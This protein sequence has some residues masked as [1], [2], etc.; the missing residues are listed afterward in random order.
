MLGGMVRYPTLKVFL[1]AL[2]NERDC[3]WHLRTVRW[4][5]GDDCPRCGSPDVNLVF[6]GLSGRVRMRLLHHCLECDYHFSATAGT[7]FHDTHL[8]LR[9]WLLAIYLMGSVKNGVQATQLK[10][11]LG[12]N[13]ETARNMVRRI[14]G[15]IKQDKKFVQ[16]CLQ[17][18]EPYGAI[19][20]AAPNRNLHPTLHAIVEKFE[21]EEGCRD[22]LARI[23]WPYGPQC[24]R[25]KKLKVRQIQSKG[26][27][28]RH[29]YR[30]LVCKY[31]FSVITGTPFTRTHL[32]SEWLIAIYLMGSSPRGCPA[33]QLQR[34]LGVNYRTAREMV[35]LLRKS[36]SKSKEVFET[37]IGA[38]DPAEFR[39]SQ[40][41]LREE[42]QR[43][44]E[45]TGK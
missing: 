21:S 15:L 43:L 19:E 38:N 34:L 9:D 25:C 18:P 35:R 39:R 11:Y 10:K 36:F 41:A 42:R 29:L 12:V 30:C 44:K 13:Y 20:P 14:R 17:F 7:V 3:R 8:N 32:L 22:H 2:G 27:R 37:Y 6:S 16:R 40:E 26:R 23:R 5:A 1:R 31:Q 28:A 4:P 33:K 45:K 24:L